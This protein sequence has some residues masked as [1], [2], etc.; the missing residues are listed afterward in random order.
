[1]KVYSA[2]YNF[3]NGFR[4]GISPDENLNFG[5]IDYS[6]IFTL[7]ENHIDSLTVPVIWAEYEPLK[8]Q[9]DEKKIESIRISL[10]RIH[11]QNI[12]P[13]I[14]LE[15]GELPLWQN[16]EKPDKKNN[17]SNERYNFAAHIINALIPY[18]SYFCLTCSAASFSS[19][20][21]LKSELSVHKDIRDYANAISENCLVGT[22][23][24]S[25][26]FGPVKSGLKKLFMRSPTD[27][28]F[29]VKT[30]FLGITAEKEYSAGLQKLFGTHR[31]PLMIMS[32]EIK[33]IPPESRADHLIDN[34]YE[35][36]EL[37]QK[38]WPVL[39]YCSGTD[40]L[41]PSREKDLYSTFSEQNALKISTEM[42][43]L[44]E[45]WVHFLKD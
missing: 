36:W 38:G 22:M 13:I 19:D 8:N 24:P 6:T 20:Q 3:P 17:F 43:F 21:L 37:Y 27:E 26:A 11:D 25:S 29:N 4:W 35:T 32:D 5:N 31:K 1:M 39:G 41:S 9:Y 45:T 14:R 18:C 30:D 42:P 12:A 44:S 15:I 28:L 7:K 34:I 23:V 10:S 2:S 33:K 16:L 40:M